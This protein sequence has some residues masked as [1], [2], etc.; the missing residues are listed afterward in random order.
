MYMNRMAGEIPIFSALF[1]NHQYIIMR[2][3]TGRVVLIAGLLAGAIASA[4]AQLAIGPQFG[5]GVASAQT[6]DLN[7][8]EGPGLIFSWQ[9]GVMLQKTLNERWAVQPELSFIR[10]GY[11]AVSQEPGFGRFI[12]DGDIVTDYLECSVLGK[13]FLSSKQDTDWYLIGGPY[14]GYITRGVFTGEEGL[15]GLTRPFEEELVFGEEGIN[16]FDLGAHI[17]FGGQF[18]LGK[19]WFF[20]E[21]RYSQG[22]LNINGGD[23][24]SVRNYGLNGV[25][26]WFIYL[27]GDR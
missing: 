4:Q 12:F 19:P 3:W 27:N 17:G 10:K 7:L 13:F 6:N 24:G 15:P 1:N 26:G 9:A 23:Q 5:L 20:A 2:Q 8:P 25:F 22:L 21:L 16:R 18:D 14:F 11:E